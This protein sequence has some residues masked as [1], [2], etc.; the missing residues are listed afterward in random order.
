[1]EAEISIIIPVYNGENHIEKCI[2]EIMK[3]TYKKFEVIVI[4]DGS[5]DN[6]KQVLDKL[7]LTDKR[8]KIVHKE[9]TGVSDTRNLGIKMSNGKYI[10][11][12]D[13]DDTLKLNAL[14]LL[15]KHIEQKS[16]IDIIIFGFE[17]FGSNNRFNDTSVLKNL[18]NNNYSKN[19][20][21]ESILL[22]KDNIYG[23]IWRAVYS[24]DLL[25]KNNIKFPEGIKLS[26]D[27]MFLLNSVAK[28]EEI[29]IDYN[30]Y[31]NYIINESSM[32]TKYIP[33]LL[34]DM[35]F[36]NQ[37]IKDEIINEYTQFEFLYF[38]NMCNTYLRF[39]QNTVRNKKLKFKEKIRIIRKVKKEYNFQ[40]YLKKV[41]FKYRSFT[42]KTFISIFMF[43]VH[44]EYI[45]VLLFNIKE[46]LNSK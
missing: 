10:M 30:E 38:C 6:T 4:N 7:A 39:V 28:A 12:L 31:Y 33:T 3:Q 23:Y 27:Y 32:S 45:Y 40:K 25:T 37:W 21:I 20:I 34:T 16:N 17:V 18:C 46:K 14:E 1:M 19:K 41:C 24:K 13:S 2:A 8:L 22:T 35:M 26:E 9:N 43:R 44:L 11:F 5:V 36:V 42:K 15:H 29:K